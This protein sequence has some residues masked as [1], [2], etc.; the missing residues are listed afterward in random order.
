MA[1]RM[2]SPAQPFCAFVK[3]PPR[4]VVVPA[5]GRWSPR[6]PVSFNR[7]E[8]ETLVN[9]ILMFLGS[10]DDAVAFARARR[11]QRRI[12]EL[13][14]RLEVSARRAG[15]FLDDPDSD[16]DDDGKVIEFIYPSCETIIEGNAKIKWF[17]NSGIDAHFI[18]ID[19]LDTLT[20][21]VCCELRSVAERLTEAA[22]RMAA[23]GGVR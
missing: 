23:E 1:F 13:L 22:E 6:S 3:S 12:V 16:S 20:E 19:D 8:W 17:I 2:D 21:T 7:A 15:V 14:E 9:R 4:G 10:D 11:R 18:L 5:A